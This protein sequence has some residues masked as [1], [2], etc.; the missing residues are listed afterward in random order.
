MKHLLM[1]AKNEIIELRRSNEV[2]RAQ[3]SVVEA[4]SAAL[5]G[6][7]RQCGASVDVA[8]SLQ[9]KIDELIEAEDSKTDPA[10]LA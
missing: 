1:Q 7:P 5:F 2:L 8:W 4:F 3:V 10:P 6:P 9:R